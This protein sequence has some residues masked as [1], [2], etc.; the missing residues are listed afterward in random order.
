MAVKIGS[1][2]GHAT[3][4]LNAESKYP[5]TFG[6]EKAKLVLSHIK[7]IQEFVDRHAPNPGLAGNR[8]SGD[9]GYSSGLDDRTADLQAERMGLNGRG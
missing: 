8:G 4:S 6:V 1:Y 7:E 2:K 5:F 9:G 3:I